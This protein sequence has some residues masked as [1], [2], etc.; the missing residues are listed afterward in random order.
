MTVYFEDIKLGDSA[1]F[2]KTLTEADI[3]MFA[4][5]SGDN[6]PVH[7]NQEYAEKTPFKTRIAHGMLTASLI[8]TILGTKLPGEGTIY[9]SQS[10]RFKAPVIIGQT[11]TARVTVIELD[12]AKKRVK[13]KTECLVNGKVVLEGESLVI[14]PSKI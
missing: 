7:L 10:A 11:V 14:A 4:A 2:G 8:S 13:M 5:A 12:S 6:N 1:E 9:L 3:L